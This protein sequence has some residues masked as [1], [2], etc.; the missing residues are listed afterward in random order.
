METLRRFRAEGYAIPRAP[1][2][3][4]IGERAPLKFVATRACVW[5][6]YVER[7]VARWT[8]GGDDREACRHQ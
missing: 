6:P 4:F 2:A 7:D 8:A 1:R 3:E 5:G